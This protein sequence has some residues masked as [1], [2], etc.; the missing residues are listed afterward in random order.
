MSRAAYTPIMT[1]TGAGNLAVYTFSFKIT[2][3]VQLLVVEYDTNGLETQRVR[4]TDT[5]YLSS[6]TPVALVEQSHSQPI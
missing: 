5:S 2:A 3:L 4:G 6:G 1:Y